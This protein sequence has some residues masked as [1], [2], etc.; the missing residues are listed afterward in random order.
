MRRC[1]ENQSFVPLPQQQQQQQQHNNTSLQ[2]IKCGIASQAHHEQHEQV[3]LR[4]NCVLQPTIA[5][6]AFHSLPTTIIIINT[7]TIAA[8][9]LFVHRR[10][11]HDARRC[12]RA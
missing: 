11:L 4:M 6:S 5:H 8:A 10:Q 1:S 9:H 12:S 2:V 3:K 7:I